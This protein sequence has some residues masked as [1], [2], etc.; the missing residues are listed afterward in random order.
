MVS[1]LLL[2]RERCECPF[3]SCEAE[4]GL[5]HGSLFGALCPLKGSEA[6]TVLVDESCAGSPITDLST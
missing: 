6:T 5:V 3:G 4:A 1:A 2:A